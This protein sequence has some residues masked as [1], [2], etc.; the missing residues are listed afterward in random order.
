M[1]VKAEKQTNKHIVSYC[2]LKV[3]LNIKTELAFLS[4]I[5]FHQ[6][7]KGTEFTLFGHLL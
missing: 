2:L 1:P 4:I 3:S 7:Q 6:P 5:H